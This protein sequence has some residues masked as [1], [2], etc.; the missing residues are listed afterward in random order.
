MVVVNVIESIGLVVM[1]VSNGKEVFDV[2]CK[3]NEGGWVFILVIMD[4]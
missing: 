3:F 2:L 1:V 4:C